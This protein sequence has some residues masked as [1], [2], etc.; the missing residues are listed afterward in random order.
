MLLYCPNFLLFHRYICSACVLKQNEVLKWYCIKSTRTR[1][2]FL[3]HQRTLSAVG[4]HFWN[5]VLGFVKNVTADPPARRGR[6]ES[7]GI[8]L[9]VQKSKCNACSLNFWTGGG[10]VM[11]ATAVMALEFLCSLKLSPHCLE[12]KYTEF[13]ICYRINTTKKMINQ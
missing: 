2:L 6:K 1:T 8:C 3:P 13:K 7:T 10:G 4:K 11:K 5:A 9:K 12:G